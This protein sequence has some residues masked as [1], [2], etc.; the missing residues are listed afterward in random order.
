[1]LDIYK[2]FLEGVDTPIPI[3]GA[4]EPESAEVTA[5]KKSK[6][7]WGVFAHTEEWVERFALGRSDV[8][9][10]GRVI[11][12]IYAPQ[13]TGTEKTREVA[14]EVV[15][16]FDGKGYQFRPAQLSNIGDDGEW[17]RSDLVIPYEV[18]R[19]G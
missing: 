12:F 4:N 16:I 5:A 14:A 11:I 3:L 6:N 18:D 9:V 15:K 17:Y 7:L 10:S 1:M 8:R 2:D 19:S 13:G